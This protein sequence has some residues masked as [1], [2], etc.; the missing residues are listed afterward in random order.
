M[1]ASPLVFIQN[2][3]FLSETVKAGN[4]TIVGLLRLG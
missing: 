1:I 2:G 3:W 4:E